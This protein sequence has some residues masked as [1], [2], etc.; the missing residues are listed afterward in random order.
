MRFAHILHALHCEPWLITER[1][2]GVLSDVLA[3]HITGQPNAG[4]LDSFMS[5][6]L[7]MTIENGVADIPIDGVIGRRLS[8]MDK[9]CGGVDADEIMGQLAA[10]LADRTVTHIMLS[11]DSPG[12]SVGGVPEL[13]AAVA[14]A[15]RIKPVM[16]YVDGLMCSA[17]YWGGAGAGAIYGGPS[18]TVGSIG[19]YMS[20]LD[21]SRSFEEMGMKTEVFKAGTYKGAGI[22]GTTLTEAQRVDFQNQVNDIKDM[23]DQ[24]VATCRG[25]GVDIATVAQGQVFMGEKAKACGLIDEIASK[26][27]ALV[28]LKSMSRRVA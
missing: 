8:K 15:A 20:I 27:Q 6:K 12:G 9:S 2:H 3:K 7:E 13:G 21:E 24:H 23:F 22:P 25:A 28:D 26:S 19:V 4:M 16:A 10:A 5:P 14:K 17:A 1:Y 11:I 18:C